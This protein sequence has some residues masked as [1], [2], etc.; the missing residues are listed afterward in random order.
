MAQLALLIFNILWLISTS[1]IEGDRNVHYRSLQSGNLQALQPID[2]WGNYP[3]R[4]EPISYPGDKR[5]KKRRKRKPKKSG[6]KALSDLDSSEYYDYYYGDNES[7]E[8]GEQTFKLRQPD[9]KLNHQ[10]I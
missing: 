1:T 3:R 7:N 2:F 9:S 4:D 10:L 5:K 8:K 6:T